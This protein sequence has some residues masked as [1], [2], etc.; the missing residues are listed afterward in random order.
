M[1]LIASLTT[2]GSAQLPPTQPDTVPS[3][4]MMARDPGL[5][6][7]GR[8]Q[9]TTVAKANGTSRSRSS[10][11]RA[12]SSAVP[13]TASQSRSPGARGPV[14]CE[15][16]PSSDA[17]PRHVAE[18]LQRPDLDVG[19]LE[20]IPDLPLVLGL[21]EEVGTVSLLRRLKAQPVDVTLDETDPA[22]A[23]A[24]RGKPTH[25]LLHLRLVKARAL[26]G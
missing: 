23:Q 12:S 2:T 10:C 4:R 9:R 25:G 19:G 13:V 8:S 26:P 24:L 6:E 11:A 18:A 3:R 20:Q 14:P 7:V 1:A 17:R 5:A 15:D 16:R 21:E 22:R